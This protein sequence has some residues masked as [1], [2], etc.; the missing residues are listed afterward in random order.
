MKKEMFCLS[1]GELRKKDDSLEFEN[2]LGDIISIPIIQVDIIYLLNTVKL[3]SDCLKLLAKYGIT[4]HY[5]DRYEYYIG[6]FFP[7]NVDNLNGDLL[8]QQVLKFTTNNTRIDLS[9]RVIRACFK[10]MRRNV[11]YYSNRYSVDISEIERLFE[12][13]INRL[14]LATSINEIML[15]EASMHKKYYSLWNDIL[16]FESFHNR[17][18]TGATDIVNILITFINSL[19]YSLIVS[20]IYK[21]GLNPTISFLHEPGK[22][23]FSLSFDIAEIFRPILVDRLI[24]YLINKKI[25]TQADVGDDG[26]LTESSI[27]R[28]LHHWDVQINTTIYHRELKRHITYRYLIREELYKLIRHLNEEKEY[29]GFVL[30]W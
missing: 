9:Q 7:K 29:S 22:S 25:I 11:K 3:S 24:F 21:T 10:N 1:Q 17:I 12:E 2:T 14:N 13:N 19:L 23:R 30:W 28:I 4:V 5:F 18:K 6:S 16:M 15:I 26:L 20:E 27:K 8:V